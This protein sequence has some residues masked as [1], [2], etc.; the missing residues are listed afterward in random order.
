M[1]AFLQRLELLIGNNSQNGSRGQ[2][3]LISLH[4]IFRTMIFRG[5]KNFT[6]APCLVRFPPFFF[7]T[8]AFSIRAVL[9]APAPIFEF[10]DIFFVDC[11][12]TWNRRRR[13]GHSFLAG[14]YPSSLL[15]PASKQFPA[16]FYFLACY[17]TALYFF[18]LHV[19]PDPPFDGASPKDFLKFTL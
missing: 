7:R 12:W 1:H 9:L 6:L 11:V 15:R 3:R 5:C 14:Q 18:F 8:R 10:V 19:V 16:V 17:S 13:E 2:A 4:V